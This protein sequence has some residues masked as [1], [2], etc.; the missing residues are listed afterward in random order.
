MKIQMK[1]ETIKR[2]AR[3]RAAERADNRACMLRRLAA[4]AAEQGPDS[5]WAEM[6]AEQLAA[7]EQ[8]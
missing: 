2:R 5:I 7:G 6:L 4:L 3:E 8:K 1:P